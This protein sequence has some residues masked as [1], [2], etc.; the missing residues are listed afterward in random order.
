MYLFAVADSG[1]I[2]EHFTLFARFEHRDFPS[3]LIW[4][5]RLRLILE[6]A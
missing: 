2:L 5:S 6:Q 4:S 3:A 1:K